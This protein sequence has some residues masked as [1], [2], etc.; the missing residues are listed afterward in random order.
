M[1]MSVAHPLSHAHGHSHNPQQD[2]E[3]ELVGESKLF[4]FKSSLYIILYLLFFPLFLFSL[5]SASFLCKSISNSLNLYTNIVMNAPMY[6]HLINCYWNCGYITLCWKFTNIT[7]LYLKGFWTPTFVN[8]WLT[9][10]CLPI[11]VDRLNKDYL[12]RS[13]DFLDALDDSRWMPTGTLEI[14]ITY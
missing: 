12:N 2:D 9:E 11:D 13:N 6:V 8:D 5:P 4:F 10:H 14:P 7:L 3:Y 1:A